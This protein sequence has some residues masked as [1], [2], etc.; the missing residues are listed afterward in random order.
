M[1]FGVGQLGGQGR[2]QGRVT[3]VTAALAGPPDDGLLTLG[4]DLANGN[5][6]PLDVGG[7]SLAAELGGLA[8]ARGLPHAPVPLA[9]DETVRIAVR[10]PVPAD[11]APALRQRLRGPSV[12]WRLAGSVKDMTPFGIMELP[13]TSRGEAPIGQ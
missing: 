10:V 7:L 4:L 5:H 13:I 8:V 3:L 1:G 9:P 11:R 12:A 2:E 6:F